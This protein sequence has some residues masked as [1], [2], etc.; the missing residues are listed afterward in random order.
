MD[1][2]IFPFGL[3][4]G[5][6]IF[7]AI[8]VY[9]RGMFKTSSLKRKIKELKGHVYQKL[10]LESESLEKRKKEF[11]KL[12]KENENLRIT[13]Q[14]L[15]QKPG[16]R[17]VLN[18]HIYQKAINIMYQ[19]ATGFA[20]MWQTSLKEAEQEMQETE[21]GALPFIKK[22]IPL[23]F[24]NTTKLIDTPIEKNDTREEG[25]NEEK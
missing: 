19:R 6:G 17:E 20:P 10:D 14:S 8:I 25:Q 1:E 4:L 15:A 24:F 21:T 5:I 18:L 16:R 11:D 7:L 12:K 9:I 22:I 3:G 13:N 2:F 23:S